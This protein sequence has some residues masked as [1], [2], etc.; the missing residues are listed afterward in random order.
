MCGI[1]TVIG[2]NKNKSVSKKVWTD[3]LVQKGRGSQGFGYCAVKNGVVSVERAETEDEIHAKLKKETANIIMF[4]HRF[5]TSTINVEE[6]AHP[7]YVSHKDLDYDYY[8]IHNG[9]I[10]NPTSLKKEHEEKGYVYT[11]ELKY[12]T[13]VDYESEVTGKKYFTSEK[14]SSEFNDSEALAIEVANV[15]DGNKEK[16]NTVGNVAFV[17]MQVYKDGVNDGKLFKIHY[18]RNSGNP[19]TVSKE[20]GDSIIKSVGGT[21]IDDNKLFTI[22]Y[23]LNG[24]ETRT[25]KAMDCGFETE[26]D[27]TRGSNYKAPV[28]TPSYH[29]DYDYKNRD[30]HTSKQ[31]PA[32][33]QSKLDWEDEDRGGVDAPKFGYR[34]EG[35]DTNLHVSYPIKKDLTKEDIISPISESVLASDL[36]KSYIIETMVKKYHELVLQLNVWLSFHQDLLE[37]EQALYRDDGVMTES[38]QAEL[39]RIKTDMDMVEE[40]K[41]EVV[42]KMDDIENNYYYKVGGDVEFKELVDDYEEMMENLAEISFD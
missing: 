36:G 3:Y 4:H 32:P 39:F 33:E 1:V 38:M 2:G 29:K 22:E 19:L 42:E 30:Y 34:T 15:L 17:A 16:I 20:H 18:G 35:K 37:E 5:P 10:K 27:K 9:V 24:R 25:E 21:S 7:I 6:C 26:Y 28:Y 13:R 8:L 12:Q 23:E 41:R 40:E 11:T 14:N 31:L